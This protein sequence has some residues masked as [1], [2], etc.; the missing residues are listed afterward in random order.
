[1]SWISSF[2]IFHNTNRSDSVIYSHPT[3]LTTDEVALE[4][5]GN[6]ALIALSRNLTGCTECQF[7][8]TLK[9]RTF[10]LEVENNIWFA[11]RVPAR[12][13]THES[14]QYADQ[15]SKLCFAFGEFVIKFSYIIFK[16]LHGSICD[17][18]GN[19][20]K[21]VLKH[22]FDTYLEALTNKFDI[23]SKNVAKYLIQADKVD[24]G[25]D[26][27]LQCEALNARLKNLC[28]CIAYSYIYLGEKLIWSDLEDEDIK[29]VTLII[30][31][32]CNGT[33]GDMEGIAEKF[34]LGFPLHVYI[35]SQRFRIKQLKFDAFNITLFLS[36]KGMKF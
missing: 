20:I 10:F 34:E 19:T 31:L 5:G 18:G 8:D 36:E 15:Q 22:H 23:Y 4:I 32:F 24:Y 7:F 27:R 35:H 26:I 16:F 28:Q 13:F 29:T 14:K 1:M 17:A 33:N 21:C 12:R 25:L 2:L 9:F 6:K 30:K 11:M 3:N